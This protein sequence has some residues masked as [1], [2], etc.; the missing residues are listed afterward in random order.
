LVS[1]DLATVNTFGTAVAISGST[2]VVGDFDHK[3]GTNQ[4]QGAAYVFVPTSSGGW[5]QSAE[6]TASNGAHGD[7]FGSSVSISG[8]TIAVGAL[9]A[10]NGTGSVYQ[11][12]QTSSG[13]WQQVAEGTGAGAA[14]PDALGSSVGISGSTIVAGAPNRA[15]G[16]NSFEGAA[17]VF[18][19]ASGSG[20]PVPVKLSAPKISGSA[21]VGKTLTEAHGTW[22]NAPTGYRYQWETCTSS[23]T[24]CSHIT[25]ATGQTYKLTNANA[26]HTVRVVETASNAGGAGSP[27]SSAATGVIH[28]AGGGPSRAQIS[29]ALKKVLVPTGK[30]A[31]IAALVKHGG[32]TFSFAAPSAGRLVLDWYFVPA[33]AHVTR[34]TKPKPVL[35]ASVTVAVHKSGKVKVKLKLTS[36]GR[37]LLK[38]AGREKLT[39]KASFA[40]TGHA[41]RTTLTKITLKR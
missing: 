22:T 19:A 12:A 1:S 5:A 7:N 6:L 3:V 39:V 2:I 33:G 41:T 4:S 24:G 10:N 8:S 25:G 16:G 30:L 37:K 27:A 26:G 29:S 28:A 38:S 40:P 20:T 31:K 18:A 13:G 14:S 35:V 11:F 34:G 21:T 15:V 32:Y 36:Q 23:G 17:Y 9:N